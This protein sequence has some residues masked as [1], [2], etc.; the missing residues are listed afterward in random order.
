M[1]LTIALRLKLI[2]VLSVAVAITV[3][4]IGLN[5]I[6]RLSSRMDQMR[7]QTIPQIKALDF[8][9]AQTLRLRV[10]ALNSAATA[11]E[12][13]E[14]REKILAQATKSD[15]VMWE[16][17]AIYESLITDPEDRAFFEKDKEAL[18]KFDAKLTPALAVNYTDQKEHDEAVKDFVKE[19]ADAKRVT[20]KHLDY[21]N[22]RIE[23]ANAASDAKM[24]S[25]KSLATGVIII[26]VLAILII[27]L[28]LA[29]TIRRSLG[30][31]QD[32]VARIERERDFTI[33]IPA[34]GQ[35]ELSE[36]ARHLNRLLQNMQSSLGQIRESALA[37]AGKAHTMTG[38]ARDL[39]STS[40]QQSEA[41]SGMAAAVEEM[42]V[43]IAHIGDRATEANRLSE[44]SGRLAADGGDI[45][46]QTVQDINEIANS[47]N[48]T[49]ER[50][51]IVDSGSDKIS[52]VVAVIREVADQTSLL[53]LNAAI[54][55][56]RAGEQGRGFAVVADEVRKL[57]ERTA[58]STTEI[59]QIINDV[60]SG[61]KDAVTSMEVAVGRVAAG[62]TRAQDATEAITRIRSASTE[63]VGMVR[64]ITEAIREQSAASQSI[65]QQVER[66]A[67]ISELS[68]QS[69][70][71]TAGT[72]SEL[73]G[74]AASMQNVVQAYQ[75]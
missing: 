66:I 43:S 16:Q 75:I 42:T 6:N 1:K 7:T 68:N 52:S 51:R 28:M 19:S 58:L 64:E 47:V 9:V 36:M 69:A 26:G 55:A 4:L 30:T 8:V 70:D 59:T 15:K 45:I 63:A 32:A 5:G 2:I 14:R 35:D 54:E 74:L 56:A 65:A 13:T 18:Q 3:G 40:G 37:V 48:Q 20:D 17:M 34:H 25:L 71:S 73:D 33:R 53:A 46:E 44:E 72:A 39:A 12:D 67:Q 41:A 61:A 22:A 10:H 21:L 62:V 57:A 50:I 31:V 49:S 23:A 27:G 60:R 38:N 11:P 29:R 24:S